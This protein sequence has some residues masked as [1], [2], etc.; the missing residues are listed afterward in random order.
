MYNCYH[1]VPAPGKK[2]PQLSPPEYVWSAILA[3][4]RDIDAAEGDDV[5]AKWES[6]FR[7]ATVRFEQI[8]N[9]RKRT[10]TALSLREDMVE[11]GEQVKMTPVQ[12]MFAAVETRTL[13]EKETGRSSLGAQACRDEWVANVKMAST[14]EPMKTGF[15]DACFTVH[16]RCVSD[17]ECLKLIVENDEMHPCPM[18]SIYKYESVCKR[19]QTLD[20]IKWCLGSVIDWHKHMQIPAGEFSSRK[21]TGRGEEGGKGILDLMLA[22]RDMGKAIIEWGRLHNIATVV[23]D[24]L[25]R[26][27]ILPSIYRADNDGMSV[28]AVKLSTQ[29]ASGQAVQRLFEDPPISPTWSKSRSVG[30]ISRGSSLPCWEHLPHEPLWH[31]PVAQ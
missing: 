18:D 30:T 22:R 9:E 31:P 7:S 10:W 2:I 27:L 23:L 3:C 25:A 14:S 15:L 12:K 19:A 26:W 11:Q 6:C 24:I 1:K 16:N 20:N 29:V 4:A 21:F 5:M 28:N 17:P 8:E 13:L